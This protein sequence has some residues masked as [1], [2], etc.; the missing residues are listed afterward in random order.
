MYIQDHQTEKNQKKAEKMN[1]FLTDLE[2]LDKSDDALLEEPEDMLI[3]E[4]SQDVLAHWRAPEH[5]MSERGEKWNLYAALILV[6]IIG[7]AIYTNS[8]IMAITFILIG[9][10]GYIFL[11]IK[12][13]ILDFK[14]TEE[15]IMAG[16]EIY[17]FDN[18]KSFWIFYDP[19]R[20]KIISLYTKGRL[21]PFVH[22]PLDQED[23][24]K[25]R[26]I[27]MEHIPEKKQDDGLSD[28]FE[29]LMG[30]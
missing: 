1:D 12:P 8:P 17:D 19:P 13:K 10:V 23:P 25:I 7:Y 29:R 3:E 26:E 11:N 21:T 4:Y 14:I 9:I 6:A 20:R 27:L 16:K 22:I 18:L 15:G 5:E 28:I 24:V 30:F 2:E